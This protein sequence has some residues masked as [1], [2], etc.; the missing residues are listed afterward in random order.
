MPTTKSPL[1]YPGGKSQLT[2]YV[3]Q[4]LEMN[5]INGTYIEAFA[6][7][8]GIAIDL[9]V[10][11][12]VKEIVIND[13]DPSIYAIWY[14]ILHD[15]DKLISMIS[16]VP[17]DYASPNA[18]TPSNMLRFWKK[19]KNI[20][21]HSD[22]SKYS[23][24]NAFA[25]LM[26]NRMN[27]SGVING[28]PI[29]GKSQSGKYK[30]DSRFNKKTLITKI[31]NIAEQRDHIILHNLDANEL[32]SVIKKSF[33]AD[34]TFIFFDPPYFVQGKNL[35]MSFFDDKQHEVLAKNI[36]SLESYYWITTYDHAPQIS[37]LYS[38]ASKRYEYSLNYSANKRGKAFE[39]L[40]A[41]PIT[42][43]PVLETMN[44]LEV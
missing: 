26:L 10:T 39:Y 20:H 29:G 37:E 17:F 3:K 7:G 14:A 42:K 41:S 28:G 40:F 38:S 18:D 24:E 21:E 12:T 19:Q 30:V 25:T 16:S 6:G 27:I 34:N 22:K 13:Y 36:L 33:D 23:I 44:M 43:L 31:K 15:T 11:G 4:N 9:L 1:R 2:K 35:Y 32:I 5:N 8:A